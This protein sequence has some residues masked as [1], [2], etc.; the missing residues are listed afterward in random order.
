MELKDNEWYYYRIGKG[1]WMIKKLGIVL[2]GLKTGNAYY[3]KREQKEF[4]RLCKDNNLYP[5]IIF[6]MLVLDDYI[7]KEIA[8]SIE[9]KRSD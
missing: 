3:T 5:V 6:N 4:I 9:Y 2:F 7:Y 1:Y 8:I